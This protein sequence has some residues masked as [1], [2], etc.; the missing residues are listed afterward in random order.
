MHSRYVSDHAN[1]S[2]AKKLAHTELLNS[3]ESEF[4]MLLI[5]HRNTISPSLDLHLLR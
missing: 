4:D 3:S 5:S 1:I 2:G